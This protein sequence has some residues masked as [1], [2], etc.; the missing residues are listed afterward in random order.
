MMIRVS[1]KRNVVESI[2]VSYLYAR[3]YSVIV[4]LL[5]K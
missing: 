2:F 1:K 3:S 4:I 5:E